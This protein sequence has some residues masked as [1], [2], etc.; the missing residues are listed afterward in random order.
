[1]MMADDVHSHLQERQR[2]SVLFGDGFQSLR[3]DDGMRL[4]LHAFVG[5]EFARA[6][7]R[8]GGI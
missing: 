7:C 5:I 2:L 8:L 3:A 6:A 4:H 1:M